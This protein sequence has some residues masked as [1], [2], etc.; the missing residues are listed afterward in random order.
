M[1]DV[2]Q[3]MVKGTELEDITITLSGNEVANLYEKSKEQAAKIAELEKKITSLESNY[4]WASEARDKA[5]S[6]ISQANTL[7]TALG[8]QLKTDA[9][10]SYNQQDLPVSTRIALYIA[11]QKG[12]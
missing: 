2:I 3:I 12:N 11:K 6:E 5:T 9:E 1:S 10:I 8:V 7:L 4:K